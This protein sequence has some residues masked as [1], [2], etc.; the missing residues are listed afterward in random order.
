MYFIV[1]YVKKLYF[2]LLRLDF[3]VGYNLDEKVNE[4]KNY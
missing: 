1:G 4:K 2:H 3:V